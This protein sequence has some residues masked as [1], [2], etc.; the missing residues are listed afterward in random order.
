MDYVVAGCPKFDSPVHHC[1]RLRAWF[2]HPVSVIFKEKEDR[3]KVKRGRK[4]WAGW[5]PKD[6]AETKLFRTKVPPEEG[7]GD[8]LGWNRL[9]RWRGV[10]RRPHRR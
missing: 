10:Q 2:H 8:G 3:V 9:R 6:A 5:R 1:A 4:A 7:V